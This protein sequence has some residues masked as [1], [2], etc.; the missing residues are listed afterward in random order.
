MKCPKCN[1]TIYLGTYHRAQQL[2]VNDDTPFSTTTY[3]LH[4]PNIPIKDRIIDLE[5]LEVCAG[6]DGVFGF[7]KEPEPPKTAKQIKKEMKEKQL[8]FIS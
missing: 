5:E 3:I 1:K 4:N 8:S 7:V 6:Y 2:K